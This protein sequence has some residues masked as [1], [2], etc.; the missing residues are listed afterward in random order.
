MKRILKAST[1]LVSRSHR[2][3]FVEPSR[4]SLLR[5]QQQSFSS[6]IAISPS[7]HRITTTTTT[8]TTI[9]VDDNQHDIEDLHLSALLQQERTYIDPETGFTVFTEL[10]HLKR[11]TCC[12]N[13][14]RH[15][16]YG[17]ENVKS[18]IR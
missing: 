11:G 7:D 14:C 18:G 15:C 8:A 10:T 12:G 5:F 3:L 13:Q 9:M 6:S 17:F 4:R 2:Y 1:S 16:P